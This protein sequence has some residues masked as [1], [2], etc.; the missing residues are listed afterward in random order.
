MFVIVGLL[1]AACGGDDGSNEPQPLTQQ[2]AERLAQ[3]GYTNYLAKGAQFEANSAF[4]G[5]GD[6]ESLTMVGTVDWERHVGRAVVRGEGREAGIVEI[7]WEE[8]FI[9]ERRPAL[10]QIVAARG[11]PSAP[12]IARAPEPASRQLDRLIGLVVGLASEQPDNAILVQQK[13]GSQ[14]IRTDTLRNTPVE[15]LRYGNRNIYWLD[16]ADGSMLRFEGNSAG[17]NAPVVIDIVERK[18][19]DIS[20]PVATDVVP[21]SQVAEVYAA[22][23]GG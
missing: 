10:D 4:L 1:L 2:Q 21:V 15:V 18:A 3:S 17:N 6:G 14:F 11:G 16:S 5:P 19:V 20:P 8:R 9:L 12:W 22:L 13:E 23:L 7:Y